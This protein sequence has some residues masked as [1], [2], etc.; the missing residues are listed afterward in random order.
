[1]IMEATKSEENIYK[2]LDPRGQREGMIKIPLTAPRLAD[3]KGKNVLV[4]TTESYPD[5]MPAVAEELLRQVPDVNVKHWD[6]QVNGPLSAKQAKEMEID[7]AIVGNAYT[8]IL[9]TDV[10]IVKELE[11]A[12]IP[13]VLIGYED[14]AYEIA[15]YIREVGMPNMRVIVA[16]HT[17]S[18]EAARAYA[19]KL[20]PELIESLVMPLT[21]EEKEGGTMPAEDFPRIAVTGTWDE[22]QEY[23]QG[24]R[25]WEEEFLELSD[26]AKLTSW[27]PEDLPTFKG[28]VAPAKLTIGLPVVLPTEEKVKWMLSGTS[29]SPDEAIGPVSQS[30]S[31]RSFTVETIAVNA[32]MAGC[33]PEY[34]PVL[35]AMA[36]LMVRKVKP[37]QVSRNGG[38]GSICVVSGPITKEIGLINY[39]MDGEGYQANFSIR[40][41]WSLIGRNALDYWDPLSLNGH[42]GSGCFAEDTDYSPWPSLG[43][44]AGFKPGENVFAI[45]RYGN[46]E[47]CW[48]PAWYRGGGQYLERLAG[49]IQGGAALVVMRQS[50]ANDLAAKGMSKQD[51]KQWI[52]DHA[53]KTGKQLR[54]MP[55][56]GAGLRDRKVMGKD[57]DIFNASDDAVIRILKNPE[58][59]QIVVA[60]R[61]M[62]YAYAAVHGGPWGV[63]PGALREGEPLSDRTTSIDKWR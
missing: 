42:F 59:V 61:M 21:A 14:M 24:N 17:G 62:E 28:I 6:F 44:D 35:L 20:G 27:L 55:S 38:A 5:L 18:P 32:V 13:A 2:C 4:V 57:A 16:P 63:L 7:A 50:V 26:P 60:G 22:C 19:P 45:W 25:E 23:F 8:I 33:K 56:Y 47:A 11:Q 49:S 48:T 40:H 39:R 36:E 51:V 34:M 12:G 30:R 58:M 3:L 46:P 1:M 54:N 15:R 43:V 37:G 52:W 53:T 9:Y 41:A 31:Y 10:D 29:H